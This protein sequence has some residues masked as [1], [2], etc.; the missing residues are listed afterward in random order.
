MFVALHLLCL[1]AYEARSAS[2]VY[3]Y[4]A[5]YVVDCA[6][7]CCWIHIFRFMSFLFALFVSIPSAVAFIAKLPASLVW[8]AS[9]PNL[10]T[11]QPSILNPKP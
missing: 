6:W 9:T 11:L 7:L 10:K 5:V 1:Y 8:H 2:G 3:I 4:G